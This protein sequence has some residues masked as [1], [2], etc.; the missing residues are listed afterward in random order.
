MSDVSKLELMATWCLCIMLRSSPWSSIFPTNYRTVRIWEA[1]TTKRNG[2]LMYGKRLKREI[3]FRR[4]EILFYAEI[5]QKFT[6]LMS[7]ASSIIEFE[8]N[9]GIIKNFIES[10]KIH[11]EDC[12]SIQHATFCHSNQ[13]CRTSLSVFTQKPAKNPA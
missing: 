2:Y 7:E 5:Q 13:H 11:V 1:A 3:C 9:F 6:Y 4:N 8:L 12:F 10:K